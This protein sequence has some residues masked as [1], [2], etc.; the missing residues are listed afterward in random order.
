MFIS[1]IYSKNVYQAFTIHSQVLLRP[2]LENYTK[3]YTYQLIYVCVV[4]FW[5]LLFVV[6]TAILF[7]V[8]LTYRVRSMN[9]V[10]IFFT[11]LV[12]I[13]TSN[14]N[15]CFR[16]SIHIKTLPY[17]SQFHEHCD[18]TAFLYCYAF[19]YSWGLEDLT[20]KSRQNMK[21]C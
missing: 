2:C 10:R 21:F 20:K 1:T 17:K 15:V 5:N 4:I 3:L 19:L 13:K 7:R 18:C 11:F 12:H 9:Y 8:D 16:K 14:A 6:M